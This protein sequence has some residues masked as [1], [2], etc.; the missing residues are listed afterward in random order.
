TGERYEGATH[1]LAHAPLERMPLYV[2]AGA[3]I[4]MQPVMQYTDERL[5]DELTL[6]IWPGEGEFRLYEDDGHTFEY[7]TGAFA[8][9]TYRVDSQGQQTRVEIAA[10]EGNWTPS[11]RETIVQLVGVG[12]QRFVDDSTARQLTF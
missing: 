9:T 3:I 11:T 12:E 7:Q 8:T 10:R 6:R 2:R 1:I 5:I 4:P